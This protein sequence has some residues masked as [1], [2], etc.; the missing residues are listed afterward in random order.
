MGLLAAGWPPSGLAERLQAVA[1]IWLALRQ[2][3]RATRGG[4]AAT[5]TAF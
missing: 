3:H 2:P 5:P 1:N 4:P